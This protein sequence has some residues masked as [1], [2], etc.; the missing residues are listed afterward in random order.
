MIVDIDALLARTRIIPVLTIER[1][2]DAVPLAE[3]LVAGGLPVLEVTLRTEAA[4]A[5]IEAIARAVPDAAIGAG[6]ILTA[7]D[8]ERARRAGA[9]FGVSPGLSL[10]LAEAL[11]DGFPFLPGA[12][13]PSEIMAAR[14][15]GFRTLK[16][17]PAEIY[18]GAAA[19]AALAAVFQD[20]RFCPTGGVREA[21]LRSF[22]DL[23]NVPVVGGTWIA[24]KADIASRDWSGIRTKAHR[25]VLLATGTLEA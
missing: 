25:A 4:L 19:L 10:P 7:G 8:L 23:P 1:A 22:L 17:F 14:D 9:G 20:I 15:F 18:G 11:E 21:N 5:A 6:T 12:V 13:T 16:Y 24:T 2:E 3:A